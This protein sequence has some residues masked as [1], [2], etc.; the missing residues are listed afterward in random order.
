MP[1]GKYSN[2]N[3]NQTKYINFYDNLKGYGRSF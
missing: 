2:V 1:A 3:E